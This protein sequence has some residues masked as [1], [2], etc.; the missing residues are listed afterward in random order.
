M[1]KFLK[2]RNTQFMNDQAS[3]LGDKFTASTLK[4]TD[5][6]HSIGSD[7]YRFVAVDVETA[8]EDN[9]TICQIGVAC[10]DRSNTIQTF[11]ILVDPD[12]EFSDFNVSVHGITED[13]VAGAPLFPEV[14]ASLR[15]FLERNILIQHSPFDRRAFDAACA[16]YGE[17]KLTSEW[18][19]SVVVARK[20][21]PELKGNGGH[22][23]ANLKEHFGLC[24][25]HHDAEEDARAAAEVVLLAEAQ[26][27]ENFLE[28]ARAKKKN[29]R[30][31][32]I[33]KSIDGNQ[34]GR[35]YGHAVC[36]TGSLTLSREEASAIAA[37]VGISVKTTV[38][39]KVTMVVVGDQD[40]DSLA[41]HSKSSKHRKA[42][43]LIKQGQSIKIM[44]EAE[45]L[46]TVR[47]ASEESTN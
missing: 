8:N 16:L 44:G 33:S 43:D 34:L 6:S 35:L 32:S 1:F 21:W 20:A 41:G 5:H 31:Y 22:G 13:L 4:K 10:V 2:R 46:S 3:G 27:G 37:G 26:T 42:E 11:S 9:S 7:G 28:L 17:P 29:A 18:I 30:N 19:D 45:F 12:V 47:D 15:A 39:K 14:L 24:F 25:N 36:F 40:L 38:T 23:L